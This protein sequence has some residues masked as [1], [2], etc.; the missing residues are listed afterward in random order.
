MYPAT[1]W[2]LCILYPAVSHCNLSIHIV[3]KKIPYCMPNERMTLLRFW[4]RNP[5]FSIFLFSALKWGIKIVPSEQFSVLSLKLKD[6]PFVLQLKYV[7]LPNTRYVWPTFDS[8]LVSPFERQSDQILR[9]WRSLLRKRNKWKIANWERG[10]FGAL[11]NF[12]VSRL[13]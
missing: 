5:Y 10:F 11:N 7:C 3:E 13:F 9:N 4:L 12:R 8:F 2:L 1:Y 6:E